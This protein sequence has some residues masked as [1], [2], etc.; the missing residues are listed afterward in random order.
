MRDIYP[1]SL[2]YCEQCPGHGEKLPA[3]VA[4]VSGPD[5]K[6][7][8]I[9]RTYLT[10]DGLKA[11]VDVTR[12]MM[13]GRVPPGSA[14]R[15]SGPA[16]VM[17]IAEGIETALSAGA[18]FGLPVWSALNTSTL[19]AWEPPME[20]RE[21]VIFGDRDAKFGGQKSAYA[22]AYR[23]AGKWSVSVRMPGGIGDWNDVL[24]AKRFAA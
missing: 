5:G 15:F 16:E 9:H 11:D 14:V 21:I 18:L 23:L 17:G 2:R 22:L 24:M 1:S 7:V 13:P 4:M 10:R 6:A 3:M 8:N 20:A 12:K 19:E